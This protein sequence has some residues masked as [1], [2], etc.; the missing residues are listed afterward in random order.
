MFHAQTLPVSWA[1]AMWTAQNAAEWWQAIAGRYAAQRANNVLGMAKRLGKLVLSRGLVAEDPTEALKR[2]PIVA[3]ERAIPSRQE[4]DAILSDIR[5][6]KKAN[7]E[8]SANF[9]EFLAFA[10]CRVSQARAFRW[11]HV[12][13]DWI[14]FH[15]GVEGTKGGKERRLPITAPLAALLG[16][17]MSARAKGP[18]FALK[19]PHEALANA[20]ERL[21][22]PHVRIH[23][24]RHF[25]ATHALRSGVD[26][27]T[28]SKWLGHKDGGVLVLRTY[29]HLCD[30][31]SLASAGKIS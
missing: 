11:E 13:V 23:D 18:L 10:G 30:S 28:V 17:M 12:E 7:S 16:R 8:E 6:Q 22:I 5:G 4:I 14:T 29:G 21:K 2:V 20:C 27:Q 3:V 1:V 9:V 26:V 31:H 19:R 24:L 15:G 25:F